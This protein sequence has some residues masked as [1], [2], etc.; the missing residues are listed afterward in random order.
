MRHFSSAP[1]YCR[2][3]AFILLGFLGLSLAACDGNRAASSR[4]AGSS[5]A[6]DDNTG[7]VLA[8]ISAAYGACLDRCNEQTSLGSLTREGCFT[9]CAEIRRQTDI[10]DKVYPSR[11]ACFD[12]MHTVELNRDLIIERYQAWCL[13]QWNHLHK[14]RGC[15][16][17]I[18][19]FYTHITTDTVCGPNA[20]SLDRTYASGVSVSPLP[21][22]PVASPAP[23]HSQPTATPPLSSG[24]TSAQMPPVVQPVLAAPAAPDPLVTAPV[25]STVQDTPK[26]QNAPVKKAAKKKAKNPTKTKTVKPAPKAVEKDTPMPELSEPKAVPAPQP[27]TPQIA[28]PQTPKTSAPTAAPT[29]PA[30]APAAAPVTPSAQPAPAAV[31]KP[32]V[33]PAQPTPAAPVVPATPIPAS[34]PQAPAPQVPASAAPA[35]QPTPQAAVPAAKA[36]AVSN[37]TAPQPAPEAQSLPPT[38]VPVPSMLERT[39]TSPAVLTPQ[40]QGGQGSGVPLVPPLPPVNQTP[41]AAP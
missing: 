31:T 23:L 38:L 3:C 16:D 13:Q 37:S 1:R 19:V 36:P 20:A 17:A 11:Q 7:P 25:P 22:P 10:R 8:D 21:S 6:P 26:Y 9:G 41:P 40:S 30:S 33:A 4:P 2:F 32:P 35:A 34:Q 29:Q 5:T 12:D 27:V 28:V 14:R 24:T 15:L 18:N 39:Y